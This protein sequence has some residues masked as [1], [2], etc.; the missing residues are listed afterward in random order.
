MKLY[1]YWN[2]S[3]AAAEV[4]RRTQV[5]GEEFNVSPDA[6]RSMVLAHDPKLATAAGVGQGGSDVRN[7][8][9][10]TPEAAGIEADQ[11]ALKRMAQT[12]ETDYAVALHA[13]LDRDQGLKVRYAGSSPEGHDEAAL[14]R[15]RQE[16]NRLVRDVVHARTV[17]RMLDTDQRDYAAAMRQVLDSDRDLKTQ[18]GL[19]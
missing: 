14:A 3:T 5:Y 4:T 6:A 2:A 18:Y 12:G 11:R 7:S 1:S 15:L 17:A 9:E 13:E 19:S 16:R 8:S 10:M